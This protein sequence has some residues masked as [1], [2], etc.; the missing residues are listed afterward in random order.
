MKKL[1]GPLRIPFELNRDIDHENHYFEGFY[2]KEEDYYIN[3]LT[4]CKDPIVFDVG[5]N[6][7]YFSCLFKS[8]GAKEVHCFEPIDDPFEKCQAKFKEIK[9]N[10]PNSIFLNKFALY[11]INSD[12][13]RIWV[14][15]L[16]NQGSSMKK[17]IVQK[18]R[19]VFINNDNELLEKVIPTQTLDNYAKEWNVK[20]I[21][22][23]KID[24]EGTEFEIL[25]GAEKMIKE[26]RIKNII[27]ESYEKSPVPWRRIR[28]K[29]NKEMDFL[30]EHGYNIKALDTFHPMYHAT[31]T[32][33]K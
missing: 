30:I 20:T 6:I 12:E 23:L 33:N 1:L 4:S 22:L 26:K 2:Q 31:L 24:T 3:F 9:L 16:H 11:N 18:F 7:G 15:R 27:F 28:T 25:L 32:I 10:W 19:R 29:T 13:E 5:S 8:C 14:S 17:E 21:D